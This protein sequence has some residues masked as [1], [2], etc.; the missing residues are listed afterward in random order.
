MFLDE[1]AI[2]VRSGKGGDGAATFRREKHVPRGGPNGGDGG[3]GGD[4]RA[5]ANSHV[6]TLIEFQHNRRFIAQDGGKGLPATRTGKDADDITI[7]VPIGTIIRDSRTGELLADLTYDGQTVTLC[8][9][10]KGGKGNTHFTSS[11]RQAPTFAEKGEPG[12]QKELTLE[13]KLLADVGL[14]GLPNAGKSTFISAVSAAKPKIADYPF[15]TIVPN[16]GIVRVGEASFVVADLPGLIEG[17]SEGK[18]LGLRF[19][20][21]AERTKALLHVVECAPIEGTDPIDNFRLLVK[22]LQNHSEEMAARPAIVALS[23]IDLMADECAIDALIQR[24]RSLGVEIFPISAV[25][26]DG[27][28]PLLYRLA[29]LVE[30][31][32][33]PETAHVLTPAPEQRVAATFQVSRVDDCFKVTGTTIERIVAM[34]DLENQEAVLYLHKRLEKLGVINSL[35][36]AGAGDGST[37][38]IGKFEFSFV[39]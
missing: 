9:G 17:A 29:E 22:E 12:E 39:D 18:G 34:T 37:V 2:M 16:L 5:V 19:L 35:R 27:L 33:E 1:A 8:K 11:V 7:R 25:R 30:E 38:V 13:L 6:N 20:K 4:V 23:K 31:Q 24:F 15:T 26:G 36:E 21:H 3:R 32:A 14:I 28:Q 10:G